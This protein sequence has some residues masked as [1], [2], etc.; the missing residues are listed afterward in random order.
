LNSQ[1]KAA[2]SSHPIFYDRKVLRTGYGAT[3]SVGRL[4][5]KDWRYVRLTLLNKTE[6]TVTIEIRCLLR[7]NTN[8]HTKKT[9]KNSK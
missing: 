4:I 5:P 8:A 6:D 3:I 1:E 7:N 9:R 2:Q